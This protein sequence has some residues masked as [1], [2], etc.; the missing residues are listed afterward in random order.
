MKLMLIGMTNKE[1]SDLIN[2]ANSWINAPLIVGKNKF[3]EEA[4]YDQTEKAYH[5]VMFKS[6]QELSFDPYG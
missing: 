3:I 6:V 5:L 4:K 2:I 1:T